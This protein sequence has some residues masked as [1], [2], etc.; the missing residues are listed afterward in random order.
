MAWKGR[1]RPMSAA[2]YARQ[3]REEEQ[4]AAVTKGQAEYAEFRKGYRLIKL[5]GGTSKKTES[6]RSFTSSWNEREGM[7]LHDDIQIGPKG[8]LYLRVPTFMG[9][10]THGRFVKHGAGLRPGTAGYKNKKP[11]KLKIKTKVRGHR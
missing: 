6:H 2:S 3:E 4:R 10:Q 1:R 9:Y 11:R 8:E 5:P 7:Y